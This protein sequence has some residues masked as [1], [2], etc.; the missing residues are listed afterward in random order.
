[1]KQVTRCSSQLHKL[2]PEKNQASLITCFLIMFKNILM[3]KTDGK[4]NFLPATYVVIFKNQEYT[5]V[6]DR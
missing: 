4:I 5:G 3:I 2:N 1:M 6:H